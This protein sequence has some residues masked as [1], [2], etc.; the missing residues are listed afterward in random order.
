M[1]IK[2]R[3]KRNAPALVILVL[4]VSLFH[5]RGLR[6]GYTFL[7]VDLAGNNL[8]WRAGPPQPL[9][10]WLISDSLYEFYPF[11]TNAVNSIR[12]AGHW[13]LWNPR[14]LHGHPVVADPLNQPFYPLFVAL[15]V[16]LGAARGLAIGL[17]LH[18]ILAAVLTYGLLRTIGGRRPAAVLGAFTYAL[19]GYMVTWFEATHRVSTLAWLPGVLWTFEIAVRRRSLRYA[20]LA[21]LMMALAILG[22][23]FQLAATFILFLGLYAIGRSIESVRRG[24]GRHAWPLVVLVITAGLGALLS[25]IQTIPFAEFLNLSQ[26]TLSQGLLDPLPVQQLITLII[27]DFYGNPASTGS[28]WGAFNFSE[29]TIYAGL[30]ALLLAGMAPF[31]VRRFFAV[32]MSLVTLAATFFIIGGPGVRLLGSVSVLKY[33]SLH[34]SAFLLPLIV[35]LL[36]AET[37]SAPGISI[38]AAALVGGILAVAA[39][40][41]IY[42]NWGQVQAH[43]QELQTPIIQAAGLLIVAIG[44]LGLRERLPHLR[45]QADWGLVGLVFVDLFLA[46]GRFNPAGP[47]ADL[48]PPTPAIDYLREHAGLHRVVAYQLDDSVLFGPNVLS[49][50]GLAEAGGYSSLVSARLQQLVRAGDPKIDVS[51][52]A[53]NNNMVAFSHPSRRLLDLLQVGYVVSPAQLVDPGVRAEF[54]V[55]E[56]DGYTG[57]IAGTHSA[58]GHFRVQDIP[59]NRLDLRFRVDPP[60]PTGAALAIRMW[61]GTGRERLVLDDR[62]N[63]AELQDQQ[64]LTLYFEPE[65]DAPG[66]TYV[67]EVA[68]TEAAPHTGVSLCTDTAGWPAI[69]VYGADWSQVYQGEVHIFERLAPLPRAYVVYAAEHIPDD[70][71]AVRRLLDGSFDLRNAVVTANQLD[72][73]TEAATPATPA[74]IVAYE[75]TR[76]VIN[77]S[78]IQQGLLILGDQFYPG[79]QAYLDGRPATV[80]RV[81]HVMRGVV[82]PA[83]DHQVVFRFAPASLRVGGRLSLAGLVVLLILGACGTLGE[84]HPKLYTIVNRYGNRLQFLNCS[85]ISD[86]ASSPTVPSEIGGI[87]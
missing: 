7:P 56:C 79:W 61:Q 12:H 82:L 33:V 38:R 57:E 47:I 69:S 77:V 26:R 8:P 55:D 74:E 37:M 16:V 84:I 11:L 72:L 1:A 41:A 43:W 78:A 10:N 15:G 21:A 24:D 6:P 27:P 50:Y 71:Q 42:L 65:R 86:R 76:V 5:A 49:T 87:G 66:H 68:A 58:S 9:Q 30:P 60:A 53:Q 28:Y 29:G 67:W 14:I 17:W 36:A 62:V 22:G 81:N 3:L 39:A 70:A 25:A 80:Y 34:R 48:M 52:M 46:G 31:C 83:G 64:A 13:P 18:A 44:L 4:G 2:C 51:W 40:L 85:R 73:P 54:V 23:Q 20:C 63:I 75:D 19:S 45:R 35:A 32:Y 59:I